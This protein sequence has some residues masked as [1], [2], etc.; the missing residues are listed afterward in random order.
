MGNFVREMMPDPQV[1]LEGRGLRLQG[2]G[3]WRT[4]SCPV[5]G[6]SD[7]L[8]VN[9]RSGGFICMAGC[10]LKGGDLVSF[11][12]QVDG[13]PFV[14]AAKQLGAWVPGPWA[15]HKQTSRGF[16]AADAL[17]SVALELNVCRV[18]VADVRNGHVPNDADWGTFLRASGVVEFV[19]T[20]ATR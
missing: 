10:G 11:V 7:S 19:A 1:Y 5:H 2:R 14:T 15:T 8:R 20:E 3:E 6:G 12:E 18:V 17:R 16:S 9:V 13:V 4:T